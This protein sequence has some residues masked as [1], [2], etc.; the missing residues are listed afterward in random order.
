MDVGEPDPDCLHVLVIVERHNDGTAKRARMPEEHLACTFK[1]GTVDIQAQSTY[2]MNGRLSLDGDY[3]SDDTDTISY[4]W[5]GSDSGYP[6]G[7]LSWQVHMA[8]KDARRHVENFAAN[9]NK[10]LHWD[11]RTRPND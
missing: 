11:G 2:R 8:T 4:E 1:P 5:V 3:E 9:V 10:Y 7:T 6:T